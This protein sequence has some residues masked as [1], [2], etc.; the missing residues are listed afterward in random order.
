MLGKEEV[1]HA[2][3]G[4]I[5][6][7]DAA[8]FSSRFLDAQFLLSILALIMIAYQLLY[9]Q[10]YLYEPGI[11][12][13]IHLGFCFA[14]VFLSL[15][16][17]PEAS[18]MKR[19]LVYACVIA[20]IVVTINLALIFED[21]PPMA[22]LPPMG[23]MVP[24]MV[25][26]LFCF[27]LS[28]A[29]YGKMFPLLCLLGFA[30][31]VF[32]PNL[33][34]QSVAPPR[35]GIP[36]LISWAAADI[37]QD[38]GVYGDL[39]GFMANYMWLF[40]ILGSVIQA[41]GGISF[42]QKVGAIVG[43]RM[44]S[45]PGMLS[46]VTS[47]L[48]GMVTGVTTAN[49]AI[50]GSFTIPLMK[51]H[52]YK[53]AQAGAIEMAASNGG[54]I[55]PPIMGMTAFVMAEFIGFPYSRLIL[56]ALIPAML[57]FFCVGLYV[58]L[59]ARKEKKRPIAADVADKKSLLME[60]APFTIPFSILVA[61]LI[62][63]FTLMYVAFW[64]ILAVVVVGLLSSVIKG[65]VLDWSEA[66][67]KMVRGV[68]IASETTIVCGLLGALTAMLEMSGLGIKLGTLAV[69]ASSGYTFVLLVFSALVCLVLGM[70]LPTV[71]AYVLVATIMAPAL[72]RAEIPLIAVHLFILFFAIGANNTPPIGF[73]IILA[74]RLAGGSYMAT[75]YEGLKATFVSYLLPFLFVYCPAIIL[76]F[77]GMGVLDIILQFVNTILLIAAISILFCK[78]G[79]SM[80]TGG[81]TV[82]V[83][84]SV[85]GYCLAVAIPEQRFVFVAMGLI[86]NAFAIRDNFIRSR[87][88][89]A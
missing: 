89:T 85:V 10:F 53:P 51:K 33:L 76:Q 24:T 84:L 72:T 62:A 23:Y 31:V 74:Q 25:A 48:I 9:T 41:F 70:G 21:Y 32:G 19:I 27:Y 17:S 80:L 5:C 38:W 30:Y 29:C 60:S 18:M 6:V 46:V 34:P 26:L 79:F 2:F 73:G 36:R 35:V 88:I 86:T 39:V 68:I 55:L 65:D 14:I 56:V 83:G 4:G 8:K 40:M 43:S 75:A 3:R 66:W 1:L 58:E 71:A 16:V 59:T 81:Q 64:T 54:Q 12:R 28:W 82:L 15:V 61:L 50:T 22:P 37:V 78:Y 42:I 44:A 49:I 20:S 87:K 69:E 57:Y 63:G 47:A 7:N 67:N 11:H 52:G 45:G 77:G 13:I